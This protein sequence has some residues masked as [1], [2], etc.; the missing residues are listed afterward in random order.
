MERV[1]LLDV[2]S[3]KTIK[4]TI[5]NVLNEMDRIEGKTED[6]VITIWKERIPLSTDD[7][8]EYQADITIKTPLT[9]NSA[10]SL[11]NT[12][13]IELATYGFVIQKVVGQTI[14]IYAMR[15]PT[16]SV[17]LTVHVEG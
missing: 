5:N 11:V 15:L 6:L 2:S 1:N 12:N 8:F 9:E 10:I 14:T 17:T 7:P 3:P 16:Q 13:V 4:E